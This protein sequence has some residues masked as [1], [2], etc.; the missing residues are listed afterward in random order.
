MS[1][2]P[3]LKAQAKRLRA[4]LAARGTDVG[5]S[6]ALELVAQAH[7][8]RDWNTASAAVGPVTSPVPGRPNEAIPI[9]RIFDRDKAYEFYRDFLGFEVVWEHRYG[10]HLPLYTE[11][12]FE[13]VRLHLSEHHGDA[14]P[15]GAVIVEIDDARGLQRRLVAADYAYAKPGVSQEEWGLVVTVHDP[16]SNRLMFTQRTA[17]PRQD[18]DSGA[19]ARPAELASP[20]VEAVDV[21]A[22]P[23]QAFEVFTQAIGDWWDPRLTAD[24]DT[25]VD[26]EIPPDAGED[27]TFRHADGHSY[28]VGTVTTFESGRRFE[29]SFCLAM[30]T[31][32]PSTLTV[33]FEDVAGAAS[34][35]TRVTLSHAGWSPGNVAERAK[36][37]EWPQLLERY[38][39]VVEGSNSA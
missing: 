31:D 7:G 4:A 13:G 26:A 35:T 8:H 23:V 33:D 10:E 18:R 36:F 6:V 19:A 15:G 17:P 20:I 28:R 32:H 2:V 1:T 37:T 12:V 27:V 22:G 21:P 30:D 34:P 11:V 24:P 16:F 39:A 9:L 5:H 38:R 3:D 25:F 29:M 14:S